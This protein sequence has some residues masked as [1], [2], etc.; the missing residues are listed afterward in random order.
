MTNFNQLSDFHLHCNFSS[1]SE[2]APEDMIKQA[3]KLGLENICFTDHNDYDYPPENG[4]ILFL[5]DFDSY[6]QEINRLREKY[7]DI[8][9][10]Y[11]GVEQGLQ[12]HLGERVDKYD[13]L[14]LLDF[15]IGST[16]IVDGNDPYYPSFWEE[17]SPKECIIQYF[18]NI[19]KSICCC[20]N[21]DVYGHIDYIIRYAP[22]KDTNYNPFAYSDIIDAILKKLIETG[23]GIEINTAGLKYGLKETNPCLSI[24]K[25]YRELGGEIITTGSDAHKPE[26][27]AYSFEVLR[28]LLEKGGFS[29][30]TIFKNRKPQFI[31]L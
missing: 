13:S 1:D 28:T 7:K 20:N 21:F 4:E 23:K 11:I 25:R 3:V 8:I 17:R 2:T 5:L 26:H 22:K 14:H 19:Y 31:K 30:Y 6:F 24:I 16:H 29:Y 9:N 27:M 10:I 12:P 15:I 18:E